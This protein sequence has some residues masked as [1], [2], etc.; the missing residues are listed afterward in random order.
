MLSLYQGLLLLSPFS[1]TNS[2]GTY[3]PV[4]YGVGHLSLFARIAKYPTQYHLGVVELQMTNTSSGRDIVYTSSVNSQPLDGSGLTFSTDFGDGPVRMTLFYNTTTG[5]YQ[6][7]TQA[8]LGR[9]RLTTMVVRPVDPAVGVPQC[10][11]L[12]LPVVVFPNSSLVNHTSCSAGSSAVMWADDM[13][14]D[15]FY[16][17]EGL[18]SNYLSTGPHTPLA[19]VS[20]FSLS[21]SPPTC[22]LLTP[23]LPLFCCA[24]LSQYITLT[25]F[26]TGNTYS[27]ITELAFGMARN[28][29]MFAHV[30]L[31]LYDSNQTLVMESQ[32]VE[33][34]NAQDAVL[35]FPLLSQV[36]LSPASKYYVAYWSDVT[37]YSAAGS[38]YDAECYYGLTYRYNDDDHISPW[39]V[40]IGTYEV[41]AKN[42][43]YICS[44]CG[45]ALLMLL[46]YVCVWFCSQAD[47]FNCN[48]LPVAVLGCSTTGEAPVVPPLCPPAEEG[49][50][51][52]SMLGVA[53]VGLLLGVGLTLLSVWMYQTG[54]CAACKREGGMGSSD[55]DIPPRQPRRGR[56]ELRT[57][58]MD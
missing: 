1:S 44:V 36:K 15:Y 8:L 31:A 47:F 17:S 29:N 26:I 18:L 49:S 20:L 48:P 10:G 33:L 28:A 7:S 38:S 16:S 6:D 42:A 50:S 58:L 45:C 30:R 24:V 3:S 54:K 11:V 4:R 35:F 56:D 53:I 46:F 19:L 5:R 41:R 32:E 14:G 51:T 12:D 23:S 21:L 27:T 43:L 52:G 57:G 9:E 40:N 55:D 39:P 22:H 25:P 37:L 34:F 13:S 2:Y